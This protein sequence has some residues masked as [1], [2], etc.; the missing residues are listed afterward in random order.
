ML[1]GSTGI[2]LRA[3]TLVVANFNDCALGD[4]REGKTNNQPANTG[5]GFGAPFWEGNTGVVV[6][7]AGD[8]AAPATTRYA[9]LQS[10][11]SQSVQPRGASSSTRR[12]QYREV[13]QS[14]SG[15]VWGSFLVRPLDTLTHLSGLTFNVPHIDPLNRSGQGRL[16]VSGSS[17]LVH[18]YADANPTL[19]ANQFVAGQTALVLFRFESLTRQLTVWIN[20]ALPDA[21]DDLAHSTAAYHGRCDIAGSA[22]SILTLGVGGYTDTTTTANL[23]LMDSIRLSDR[24]TAYY[25]V[26]GLPALPEI[27]LQPQSQVVAQGREVGFSVAATGQGEL[28]YQWLKDDAELPGATSPMLALGSVNLDAA[29][30]YRVRIRDEQSGGAIV[31]APAVLEVLTDVQPVTITA[32]PQPR[33]VRVGDAV[34]FTVTATGTEPLTFAWQRNG[35]PIPGATG[36]NFQIGAVQ[37][38]DAGHYRVVVANPAGSVVSQTAELGVNVP[39]QILA[40]PQ[41]AESFIG[42]EVTFVVEALGT[43]L[44]Y[45]WRRDTALL[46]ATGSRLTLTN[47]RAEDAGSYTVTVRNA[48]GEVASAPA[49][50]TLQPV[51]PPA[52]GSQ[53][54]AAD[55]FIENGDQVA[56]ARN[57]LGLRVAARSTAGAAYKS[58]LAF[59]LPLAV[60]ARDATSATLALTLDPAEPLLSGTNTPEASLLPGAAAMRL[61]KGVE[62]VTQTYLSVGP[63]TA[64]T[65][66]YRSLITFDLASLAFV[67]ETVK[68]RFTVAAKWSGAVAGPQTLRLHRVTRDWVQNQA[69]WTRAA[70]GVDWTTPGGDFSA[71]V[72]SQV[73]ADPA[74]VAVGQTIEFPDTPEL[75]QALLEVLDTT[76]Q[77]QLIVVAANEDS[78]SNRVF[79]FHPR[80]VVALEPLL[81]FPPGTLANNAP[82]NPVRLRLHGVVDNTDAWSETALAWNNA[83]VRADAI[84]S[85]GAGAVPLAEITLDAGSV[86]SGAAVAFSDAR[87]TQFL[88]WA[89]GRRGNLYGNGHASDTDRRVTFVLTA[90]DGGDI[91]AGAKF[92]D[93]ENGGAAAPR[94]EFDT[95]G[96]APPPGGTTL[97]NERYRV[98]LLPDHA[99]AVTDK[100]DGA[101]AR[102]E[103]AFEAISQVAAPGFSRHSYSVSPTPLSLATWNA[104]FNYGSAAGERVALRPAGSRLADGEIAWSYAPATAAF[105][106]RA[107]LD[108]PAGDA[109]PRLRWTLAP[110]AQRHFAVAFHPVEAVPN[111]AVNAFYLPG[112]WN[113]RRFPENQFVIDEVRATLPAVF[114]ETGGVVSGFAVDAFEVPNRVATFVN[115]LF[116][117]MTND[118]TAALNRPAV[119]APLYGGTGSRTDGTQSFTVRLLVGGAGLDA[120]F[121]EVATGGFGFRDYRENLAGGSLNTALDNLV[122]FVLNRSGE[123][124]SYWRENEKANEYVNDNPDY[125]RFQSA[126]TALGLA[127]VRDDVD[128]YERRARPT[129]EYFISRKGQMMKFGGYDPAYGMGGPVTAYYATDFY[130]LFGLMGGRTWAFL[131]LAEEARTVSGA[132][133]PLGDVITPGRA[134]T[135]SEAYDRMFDTLHSLIAGYR[136]TGLTEYLDD[137]RWLIDEYLRHRYDTGLPTDFRDVRS[138]FWMQLSG[139]WE[140]LLEMQELTGDPRYASAA[141]RALNEFARHINF[142]PALS[143]LTVDG[144]GAPAKAAAV[145]EVG[146][147]S[148][149]TATSVS[150]RGIFMSAYASPSFLRAA[151][152]LQDPFFAAVGRSGIVGRWLNYPG[153]TIRNNYNSVLLRADYPLRWYSRYANTAH[154]N[155]PLPLAAMAV[156]FL[157]A[158]AELKSAGAIRFPHHF[159]DS[160]AYFRGRLFGGEPGVFYGEGGVWPWLPRALV[161]LTG[162]DAVQLNYVAGH[163]NARLYVAFLN[164]SA[165]PVEAVVTIDA[166]RVT[167]ASGAALRVRRDNGP[168]ETATFAN[169]VTTVRVSPGGITT[170]VIEQAVPQ[171]G[172]QADYTDGAGAALGAGSYDRRTAAFGR[173]VGAVVSLSPRRQ[174]AYV[175]TD[176]DP[177]T[178]AAARLRYRIDDGAE[179]LLTKSEFPFEFTVPLPAGTRSVNYTLEGVTASGA[180]QV[181]PSVTLTVDPTP[182]LLESPQPQSTIAGRA[183]TLSVTAAGD[184]PFTYQ[185]R[186]NGVA[187]PGATAPTLTLAGVPGEAGDYDVLVSNAQGTTTSAPARVEV[188]IGNLLAYALGAAGDE[189]APALE[190]DFDEPSGRLTLAF[191]RA[192]ADVVYTV[193]ASSDLVGWTDVAVNPGSVGQRVTVP[194]DAVL[195]H[196]SRRFLRLRVALP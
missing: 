135:R 57:G 58:Y 66:V 36:V 143:Q 3:S 23:A 124:Y 9:A 104:N 150:H 144:L 87:L 50:L 191:L 12:Q 156:D 79:Q 107:T 25:D 146:L 121:R 16:Y 65:D 132:T 145:S 115:S 49:Q 41:H 138:S 122:D 15:V 184:G 90:L 140:S 103:A 95:G 168:E 37:P 167:V 82:K 67:P 181:G 178:L 56:Q 114:R 108:L 88:N 47:L 161:S 18:G 177:A 84:S 99:V 91:F 13:E 179:Q 162:S 180:T 74:A 128:L 8:L 69:N 142:G 102:F 141:A 6:V 100:R 7:V 1:V 130:A 31:S 63:A 24:F 136:A 182:V 59:D 81:V 76:G 187:L 53:G 20:P 125:V 185:W 186:R 68:V 73:T 96:G 133:T 192:R 77:L 116:G 119:L 190:L 137:A 101:T 175:Y 27:Q 153:Y 169:G 120:M 38:A 34:E 14:L 52:A 158:D 92:Q 163:G 110:A 147:T 152:L 148:E 78:V 165:R 149:A 113:G 170:F 22:G 117:L 194:D 28:V 127:M 166:A 55:S 54:V 75:R 72:L 32:H 154:M 134:L 126:P 160:R 171:L 129:I 43:D 173:V 51:A 118:A 106:F 123:N 39:P 4:M 188:E 30:T 26:T 44:V 155:H 33:A 60:R 19:V 105:A 71:T 94:L 42:G 164:Q 86:T 112:V 35:A 159:T 193:Q 85:P 46:A 196:G 40:A 21:A 97:E 48:L 195:A 10:G 70:T 93:R 83:P 62:S 157:M 64:G 98:E 183:V 5:L 61:R 172:L 29:G 80:G 189:G 45:E 151:R 176:A 174:H 109:F 131:P 139:R 11:A 89:A 17:L 2:G 111:T